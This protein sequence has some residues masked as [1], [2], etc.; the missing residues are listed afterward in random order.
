MHETLKARC[1]GW[2]QEKTAAL[3]IHFCV[4][5]RNLPYLGWPD[6]AGTLTGL[7]YQWSLFLSQRPSGL[8]QIALSL[9]SDDWTEGCQRT[10]QQSVGSWG[11]ESRI[12][13]C[14]PLSPSWTWPDSTIWGRRPQL[15]VTAGRSLF[16]GPGGWQSPRT[17]GSPKTASRP[18][19]VQ[20]LKIVRL[21]V[22]R[23]TIKLS[24]D[25]P[26]G[27]WS[28]GEEPGEH[29]EQVSVCAKPFSGRHWQLGQT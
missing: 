12:C 3:Q 29:S 27:S 1:D 5:D 20:N 15:N 13:R 16:H 18:F 8:R 25:L 6:L 10:G 24:I 11:R 7:D 9:G 2:C 26:I 23:G 21:E 28:F 17:G 14:R 22:A 19:N 4:A